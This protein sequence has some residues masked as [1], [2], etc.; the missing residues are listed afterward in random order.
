MYDKYP[1]SWIS[2]K[3]PITEEE[4]L[5]IYENEPVSVGSEA[6]HGHGRYNPVRCARHFR[7][8]A[9]V[10]PGCEQWNHGG[11][12]ADYLIGH[13]QQHRH[14]WLEHCADIRASFTLP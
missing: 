1:S 9:C 14:H 4:G 7:R 3:H 2:Q 8:T 6:P 10:S 11:W 13:W 5:Y 12:N